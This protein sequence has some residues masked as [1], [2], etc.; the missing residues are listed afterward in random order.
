MSRNDGMMH[1]D[2]KSFEGQW[3][4]FDMDM[5][6]YRFSLMNQYMQTE[7]VPSTRS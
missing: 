4:V 1:S 3:V 6:K 5:C 2:F 7:H